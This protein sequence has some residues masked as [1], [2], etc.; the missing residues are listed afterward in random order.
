MNPTLLEIGVTAFIITASVVL[1]VWFI[2]RRLAANSETR[3]TRMLLHTGVAPDVASDAIMQEARSRCIRCRCKTW[4]DKWFAGLVDGD[5][6]FCPNAQTFRS[7]TITAGPTL[8]L[9][10][11]A[12]KRKQ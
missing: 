9:F 11:P 7:L 2:F 1:T 10:W 12:P 4:C 3:M 5:N 6:S 8:L